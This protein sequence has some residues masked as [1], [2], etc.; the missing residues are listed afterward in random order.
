[1][2]SGTL[3][4]E[5]EASGPPPHPRATMTVTGR[6]LAVQGEPLGDLDAELHTDEHGVAVDRL[7][8]GDEDRAV[9]LLGKVGWRGELDLHLDARK[10][11]I[12]TLPGLSADPGL[13]ADGLVSLDIN[14]RGTLAAPSVDG[15]LQL[16]QIAFGQTIFGAGRL[17]LEPDGPGEVH[18][19][20]SLFQGKFAVDGR[21]SL[22]APYTASLEV[23]FHRVEID[24]FTTVAELYGVTGWAS[25]HVKLEYTPQKLAYSL[26]V[27][28]LRAEVAGEDERGRP[29]PVIVTT[30]SP[31]HVEYDGKVATLVEPVTLATAQGEFT[32]S[33]SAGATLALRVRGEVELGLLH[34]FTYRYIDSVSGT[35]STDVSI[36]GTMAAPQLE[37]SLTFADVAIKPRG[38]EAVLGLPRGTIRFDNQ[39]IGV[40][41]VT[42]ALDDDRLVLTGGV[43]LAA[44]KPDRV[45]L[46]LDGRLSARLLEL[47]AGAQ[48]SGASGSAAL[49]ARLF[50]PVAGPTVEGTIT[51]DSKPGKQFEITLR[52]LGRRVEVQRG[53]L[54]LTRA[55]E[56]RVVDLGGTS[57]DGTFQ[58]AGNANI[59]GWRFHSIDVSASVVGMKYRIPKILELEFNA[60]DIHLHGTSQQ[61][62]LDGTINVADGRYT[63][64]FNV[65]NQFINPVRTSERTAPFWQGVPVLERLRLNM[66]INTNGLFAIQNNIAQETTLSGH[67]SISGTPADP[68]LG[69]NIKVEQ[70]VLKIPFAGRARFEVEPNGGNITFNSYQPIADGARVS[71]IAHAPYIDREERQYE[72]TLRIEGPLN[73]LVI[74]LTTNTG[75]NFAQTVILIS[76]NRTEETLRQQARGD[77]S[78]A[79]RD[80]SSGSSAAAGGQGLASETDQLIKGVAG[81]ALGVFIEDPLKRT[82]NID[83][84][85]LEVGTESAQIYVCKRIARGVK[86]DGDI[87][88]GYQGNATRYRTGVTA[89]VNN[90]MS[91]VFDYETRN[92]VTTSNEQTGSTRMELKFR[93]IIP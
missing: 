66:T 46:H 71:L 42:L 19:H 93:W 70:G 37:G 40:E 73:R 63:Q 52:A 91:L 60:D 30:N 34:A 23:E 22:R 65:V 80:T 53:T 15:H 47:V 5:M 38:N 33:G 9:A 29:T 35:A 74:D 6:G 54:A 92:D 20:G 69:G 48:V 8:L 84:V 81:D 68:R 51:F 17:D 67:V 56:V 39:R 57:E 55:G 45:D 4:F 18:F 77:S 49:T 31:I 59:S 36:G 7:V 88:Y 10:I 14:A 28:E 27:D 82:F 12:A 41:E 58:I 64:E 61:L 2:L 11:P 78:N 13:G 1:M 32:V 86:L 75:M 90:Y 79:A 87:E 89:R 44:W 76:T 62:A 83:C 16:A 50:G 3:A 21:A 85:R 24:E 43:S 72:I 26:V 25:G